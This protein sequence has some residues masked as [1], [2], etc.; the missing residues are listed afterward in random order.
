MQSAEECQ[1]NVTMF[2]Y[3]HFFFCHFLTV[4][5]QTTYKMSGCCG[6]SGRPLAPEDF[7]T[8]NFDIQG[9][10]PD[11]SDARLR[12]KTQGILVLI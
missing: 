6:T 11:F 1:F 12:L 9:T 5:H 2:H 3:S 8:R 7:E 10:A 4:L